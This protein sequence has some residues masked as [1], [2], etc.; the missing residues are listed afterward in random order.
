MSGFCSL[1]RVQR[2]AKICTDGGLRPAYKHV[3]LVLVSVQL[4]ARQRGQIQIPKKNASGIV[5]EV[6][7]RARNTLMPVVLRMCSTCRGLQVLKEEHIE[8]LQ[9][10]LLLVK[11]QNASVEGLHG[12]VRINVLKLDVTGCTIDGDM[13]AC[14]TVRVVRYC[15]TY[16]VT[17]NAM[18][19]VLRTFLRRD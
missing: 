14:C 12:K 1:V 11:L 7:C 19:G 5:Y 17:A 3:S 8:C 4:I 18:R 10:E 2:P 15:G 6:Y 9:G 13:H 16:R